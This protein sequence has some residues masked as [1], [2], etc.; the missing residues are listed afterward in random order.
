MS[1]IKTDGA[2]GINSQVSGQAQ[3]QGQ[4]QGQSN[5]VVP[6]IDYNLLAQAMI[7]AQGEV[8][9]PKSADA[10]LEGLRRAEEEVTESCN[11]YDKLASSL[12][13]T[14]SDFRTIFKGEADK[15]LSSVKGSRMEEQI[16]SLSKLIITK[17]YGDSESTRAMLSSFDKQ[18]AY[19]GS[20]AFNLKLKDAVALG[21]KKDAPFF[22]NKLDGNVIDKETIYKV[23]EGLFDSRTRKDAIDT[24]KH[25]KLLTA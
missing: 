2:V 10:T 7:K 20:S 19:D 21:V 9:Q 12:A 8:S 14:I 13:T 4:G 1:E 6:A 25:F 17:V 5:N 16:N 11:Y 18:N 22:V 15:Y 3:T 23:S 24:G